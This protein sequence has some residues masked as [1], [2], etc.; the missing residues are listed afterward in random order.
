MPKDPILWSKIHWRH[1][2]AS[3]TGSIPWVGITKCLFLFQEAYPVK[4]K[5]VHVLNVSPLV[6]TIYNIVKPFVKE[7]IRN[8]VY[9]HADGYESLYKYVPK[10]VLPEEYGGT[11]GPISAINGKLL[12]IGQPLVM[13]SSPDWQ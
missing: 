11:C 12:Y 10:D 4:V 8:R 9:F 2:Q 13:S 5:E 1:S 6:D 7:K 3:L